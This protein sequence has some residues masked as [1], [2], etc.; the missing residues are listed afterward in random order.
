MTPVGWLR[1]FGIKAGCACQALTAQEVCYNSTYVSTRAEIEWQYFKKL[2]DIKNKRLVF[3][4]TAKRATADCSVPESHVDS[5][6]SRSI[7]CVILFCWHFLHCSWDFRGA[8]SILSNSAPIQS[9]PEWLLYS[10]TVSNI[11]QMTP[12]EA[13]LPLLMFQKH[14]PFQESQNPDN[15]TWIYYS[16]SRI[17]SFF[18]LSAVFLGTLALIFFANLRIFDLSDERNQTAVFNKNICPRL[19]APLPRCQVDGSII[20]WMRNNIFYGTTFY[21]SSLSW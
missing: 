12:A 14:I 17:F 13:L 16:S 7:R 21:H 2:T 1:L 6:Y 5:S 8:S 11:P 15:S 20:K 10:T 4:N 18:D 19:S 9:W 3:G